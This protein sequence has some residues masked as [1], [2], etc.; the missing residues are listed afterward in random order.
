[1]MLGR[2]NHLSDSEMDT[3]SVPL[4]LLAASRF[5]PE[6]VLAQQVAALGSTCSSSFQ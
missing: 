6:P 1:M 3:V 2:H 4:I 5:M